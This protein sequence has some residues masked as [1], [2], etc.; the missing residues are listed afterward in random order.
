M[1]KTKEM[2]ELENQP[3]FMNHNKIT[4]EDIQGDTVTLIATIT[5]ES[6]NPYGFVHGGLLFGLADQAMGISAKL[7]GRLAV[8]STANITYIKPAKGKTIKAVSEVIKGGKTM[9]HLQTKIYNEQEELV[10]I[11][12]GSYFYIE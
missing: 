2:K 4:I 5:E 12:N 10:A 7:T 3:G 6:L 8:T 11:A 9:V 1:R